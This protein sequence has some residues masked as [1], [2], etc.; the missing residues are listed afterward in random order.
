MIFSYM[1]QVDASINNEALKDVKQ[2][3]EQDAVNHEL[4]T[5]E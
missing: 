5:K 1:V 4:L 3:G 2:Q